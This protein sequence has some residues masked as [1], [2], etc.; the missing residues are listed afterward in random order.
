MRT[1]PAVIALLL[2]LAC[3]ST[4]AAATWT[5][6]VN[7]E[8]L[9]RYSNGPDPY[10][11]GQHRGIDIAA[12]VGDV[13]V[14]ATGGTVTFAGSVGT[15]GLTVGVR[16]AD[17][18]LDTSY[19][20]LGSITVRRGEAV[21]T[22]A[23]I[24]TVGATGRRSIEAPHLHFGVRDAGT[25]HDYRNPLDFLPLPVPPRA[26]ETPPPAAVPV[27]APFRP[28]EPPP[29]AAASAPAAA[30]SSIPALPP[31]VTLPVL[32]PLSAGAAPAPLA[33]ARG[34]RRPLSLPTLGS[35]PVVAPEPDGRPVAG[36]S[37]QPERPGPNEPRE[38][39]AERGGALGSG[40]PHGPSRPAQP[41]VPSLGR[42][43][44]SRPNHSREPVPQSGLEGRRVTPR[45]G[46][47]LDLGLAA[48]CAALLLAAMALAHPR[49]ARAVVDGGRQAL[50][51]MLRP[52]AG[53]G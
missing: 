26:P 17:A 10:A 15:S 48:A 31:A 40:G 29:V 16:T 22:G 4:S 11:A 27:P 2:S 47:D 1:H 9:T 44:G 14:A 32:G 21:S 5:W 53:R 41:A 42:A 3:P 8:V 20:H 49:R 38:R 18:A 23:P 6:P 36:R 50:G 28:V 35:A 51:A 39:G 52:L 33:A 45:E 24:G 13:V 34:E 30:P 37:S 12:P 19:L 46:D 43:P 25:D 7:G